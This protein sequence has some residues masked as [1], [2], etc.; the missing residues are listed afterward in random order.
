MTARILVTGSRT[1]IDLKAMHDALAD[2][3]TE[4]AGTHSS[5]VIVHGACPTGADKIAVQWARRNGIHHEPHPAD[6]SR[7]GRAA[8]PRRNAEMV[9][10]G[11]DLCLAFIADG[12]PGASGCAALAES[13]GIPVRR[14]TA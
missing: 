14:W 1:W 13:A 12:S 11:A 8:G 4:L 10:L 2:A 9:K 7:H 3:V 6:W 5:V